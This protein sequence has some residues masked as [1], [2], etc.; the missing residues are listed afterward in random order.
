MVG[1]NIRICKWAAHL[2]TDSSSWYCS[3]GMKMAKNGRKIHHFK[4][5]RREKKT[6]TSHTCKWS[7]EICMYANELR[8][9]WTFFFTKS[10]HV[11]VNEM[12]FGRT[13]PARLGLRKRSESD[14]LFSAAHLHI[15]RWG[16]WKMSGIYVVRQPFSVAATWKWWFMTISSG[17]SLQFLRE[18]CICKWG[19]MWK[20]A[21]NSLKNFKKNC[22][23]KCVIGIRGS[24]ASSNEE[25]FCL[26]L[27]KESGNVR[28]TAGRSLSPAP[29]WNGAFRDEYIFLFVFFSSTQATDNFIK[30]RE[31]LQHFSNYN[32]LFQIVGIFCS[33][34]IV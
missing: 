27:R 32:F 3:F 1:K 25:M 33:L 19:R 6:Q 7:G 13:E 26:K 22:K 16:R 12:I 31:M 5:L 8:Y 17:S 14:R 30:F 34:K 15:C 29:T 9:F 23:N 28:A 10:S 21:E 4:G 2:H 20:S 18:I 24:H 11:G